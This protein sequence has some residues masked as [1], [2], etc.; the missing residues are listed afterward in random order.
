MKIKEALEK[1]DESDRDNKEL[2]ARTNPE[3]ALMQKALKK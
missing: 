2:I 1:L 3:L